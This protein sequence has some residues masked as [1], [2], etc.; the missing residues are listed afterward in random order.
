M[1]SGD[2]RDVLLGRDTIGYGTMQLTGNGVWGPP[3]DWSQAISLIRTAYDWGV[4]LFDTAW[5]YGPEVTHRLLV[6]AL[7]PFPPDVIVLTKAGNSRGRNGSW[8]PALAAPD[9]RY[10]CEQ[11]LRLL[12]LETLPLA[13]LRWFPLPGDDGAFE[14][15]LQV[16]LGLKAEGKVSN[17]GLSNVQQRHIDS[18]SAISDVAAVSNAFSLADRTDADALARCNAKRIPYLP[19]YPLLSGEVLIQPLVEQVA[20]QL[21]V[22]PAQI[23]LAWL[24]TQADVVIPIPGTRDLRHLKENIDAHSLRI[25]TTLLRQLGDYKRRP[26]G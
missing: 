7:Y 16:M 15:A 22:S 21:S 14:D 24:R 6:E 8:I 3:Q 17:I 19:Y 12:R 4:R 18:A 2:R 9:L 11:D 26:A 13:L 5:Y 25:P 20:R 1:A 10:A 23:A